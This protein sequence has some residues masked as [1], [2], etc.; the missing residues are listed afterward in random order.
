MREYAWYSPEINV[1]VF[2]S[3]MKDYYIA[4]EWKHSDMCEHLE[5]P[6]IEIDSY[7]WIPLGE[8]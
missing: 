1:I 2:Q 3:I 4:F 5:W 7:L 8:V 6:D